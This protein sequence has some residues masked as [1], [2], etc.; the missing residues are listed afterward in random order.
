MIYRRPSPE[1]SLDLG[2]LIGGLSVESRP[3]GPESSQQIPMNRSSES[4]MTSRTNYLTATESPRRC[5]RRG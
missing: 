5:G 4:T 1:D 3:F 2:D